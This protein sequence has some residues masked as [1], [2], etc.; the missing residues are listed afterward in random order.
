MQQIK[1]TIVRLM[2]IPALLTIGLLALL[3]AALP[4]PP[5]VH[6]GD[7]TLDAAM[8]IIWQ[9]TR[10]AQQTREAREAELASQRATAGAIEN[11]QRQ[12]AMEA[13]RSAYATRLVIEAT[14]TRQAMD[15]Q[16][17]REREQAEATATRSALDAEATRHAIAATATADALRAQDVR[18]A[19]TA[20]AQIA[21]LHAEATRTALARQQETEQR[22]AVLTSLGIVVNTL[23]TILAIVAIAWAVIHG[24]HI[25]V[26]NFSRPRPVVIVEDHGDAQDGTPLPAEPVAPSVTQVV[27]FDPAVAEATLD[28]IAQHTYVADESDSN[29]PTE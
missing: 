9:A 12:A 17:T 23:A 11:A 2:T 14:A 28:L 7:P 24:L 26:R 3:F 6:A 13:T 20:T 29:E 19:A 27:P 5:R 10:S 4:T 25:V 22:N 15:L 8:Q 21:N 18:A 16:A 1:R